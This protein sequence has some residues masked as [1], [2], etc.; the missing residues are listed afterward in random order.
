M[1]ILLDSK[2]L[3]SHYHLRDKHR[4]SVII[5]EL[6]LKG[7]PVSFSSGQY[8]VQE[9]LIKTDVLVITTRHPHF[10]SS[11]DESEIE[12][13]HE[14]IN[15]GGGLLLMSNHGP[16]IANQGLD[17]TEEDSR[18]VNSFD[19]EIE[20]TF[21]TN[22]LRSV[23]TIISSENQFQGRINHKTLNSRL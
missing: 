6:N 7:H 17:F 10:P 4:L 16:R 20:D 1:N 23:P 12:L 8:I 15:N 5:S 14:F 13:I 21:F 9:E 19:I 18:L 11:V 3:Q 22:S 2:G